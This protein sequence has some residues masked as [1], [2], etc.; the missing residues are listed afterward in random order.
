M[1]ANRISRS[2]ELPRI[3]LDQ[4]PVRETR[5]GEIVYRQRARRARA[6]RSAHAMNRK[7]STPRASV[8]A[9]L[10]SS[11][12]PEHLAATAVFA[13]S[14]FGPLLLIH[15]N[16]ILSGPICLTE[17]PSARCARSRR[18]VERGRIPSD[19]EAVGLFWKPESEAK[20]KRGV[21]SIRLRN[22]TKQ[23]SALRIP[24][25]INELVTILY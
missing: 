2:S 19:A 9:Q 17:S 22:L 11:Y 25:S 1:R 13:A 24:R 5:F 20:K 16:R 4:P 23:L 10:P 7:F 8:L 18:W 14:G 12:L 3:R 21:A 15:P 6:V